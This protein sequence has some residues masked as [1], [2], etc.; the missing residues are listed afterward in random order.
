MIMS[1]SR[2]TTDRNLQDERPH[3][4]RRGP[5]F[6]E[7]TFQGQHAIFPH[8]PG[9][10]YV[11]WLLL[12][13]PPEPIHA[14]ALALDAR[15]LCDQTSGAE[16]AIQLRSLGLD[17]AESVRAMRRRERELEAVVDNRLEVEPVR[18]EAERELEAIADF[19]RTYPWRSRD[20]AEKCTRVVSMA[21]QV[22]VAH[23]AQAVDAQGNPHPGLRVFA[24]HLDEHLLMPSSRDGVVGGVRAD[25]V[26]GCFTYEPPPGVVWSAEEGLLLK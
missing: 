18:A 9:A 5:G 15:T 4:L 10:L 19:L 8:E 14:V 21:I 23:L 13:P 6:W 20:C 7:V 16:E 12:H 2:Q 11:A 1:T 24:R 25:G 17:G 3:A 26:P 22:L